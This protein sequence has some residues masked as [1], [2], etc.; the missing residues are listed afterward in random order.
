MLNAVQAAEPAPSLDIFYASQTG[1]GEELANRVDGAV[2]QAGFA[3][4]TRS[5][6]QLKP[7]ALKKLSLAVFVISTHGEGDPPDDALDLFE[8]L[9]S[10]RAPRLDQLGFRVLALGDSSYVEF[11]E[12]GK[13]LEQLLI[14]RGAKPVADRIDCDLDYQPQAERFSGEVVAW[15]REDLGSS[16]VSPAAG[17][18]APASPQLALV[19]DTPLWSRNRPF[20]AVV[21]SVSGLTTNG[22]EKDVR[23]ISLSLEGSGI[24]YEPGDSLGVRAYNDPERVGELLDLLDL[25]PAI[26]TAHGGS[27]RTLREWLTRHFEL[28]RLAPDTVKAWAGLTAN[29]GLAARLE[30]MDA[31]QLKA[32]IE[33]RQLLDLAEEFPVRPDAGELLGILRPLASRSYSIASS[34]AA[35]GDEVDLTV[36]THYSQ[37]LQQRRSGVAS[38]YL[39][40]R[41]QPGD[42]VG[43]FLESNKRFRLPSNRKMPLILIAAGTGIAPYRAFFQQLEEEGASPRSW[44]IFGNQHMRTDFLYQAE[45]LEWRKSGLL[46]R[47]DT[48][49]SRD[50]AEKRYVQ[51]VVRENAAEMCE[52]LEWGA[53]VFLCGSLAMGQAV[54]SALV[55]SISEQNRIS[56]QA[57]REH[58]AQLRRE[59][60]F[61]K[62]LY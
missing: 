33:K 23:H 59:Q 50:Q 2:A 18:K 4:N 52:W 12:A 9:E 22:S 39:N 11:C 25:D 61:K 45:W 48:A 21:E 42:E 56:A 8:L 19:A 26:K 10:S 37:V 27:R 57:A 51:H 47:I 49:F 20:P 41:L 58:L 34:Q 44:L 46:N 6:Q 32:F 31:G 40:Q 16:A 36:V 15:C 38:E 1:N 3:A 24:R 17:S 7:A 13:K 14:K 62:D 43:V 5:L 53:Q 30:N 29:P 55:D 35:V 54:E 28:T 60:R